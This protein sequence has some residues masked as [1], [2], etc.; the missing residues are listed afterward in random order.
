M[1]HVVIGAGPAGVTACETLRQLD[2]GTRITLVGDE[3]EPPYSRMAIP[4]F[5]TEKIG[6]Q[7]THLKSTADF[8]GRNGINV[9]QVR[10]DRIEP[11]ANRLRMDD[12]STLDY[13][14]LL[15][16]TGSSPILPSVPG[17]E[18]DGV[19]ACW[20]LSD[21]RRIYRRARPG[22]KVVLL[23]AGF[24]GCIVLEA[25]AKRWVDL[26]VVEPMDRMVPRMMSQTA[27]G[28]LKRWCEHKGVKVLTG[29]EAVAVQPRKKVPQTGILGPMGVDLDNGTTL[30]ADL[31]IRATGVRPNV[32]L[33]AGSG[34][35]VDQ[36]ILVNEYL[37]TSNENVFAA[38]DACQGLDTSTGEFRVQAIQPTAVDHGRIAAYNMTSD[39]RISHSG[40]LN[41]NVLDTLGLIS[42]SFGLWQGVDGGESSELLDA[43]RFRYL[44]LQF[45]ED[46]L[47]GATSL[48]LTENVGVIR[49]L[50]E[51]GKGLGAWKDRLLRD[52]TRLMEAYLG[53]VQGYA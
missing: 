33:L 18:S 35:A 39:R 28:L 2:P 4:Y 44:N 26:T 1:H 37:M 22:R 30:K 27:G 25:L 9:L 5:L 41:M 31:I 32:D 29:T 40:S 10:V 43:D 19:L 51:S 12:G 36:G 24:I 48:G 52:P 8:Y 23:G 13:D 16:A 17:I 45:R 20:T 46:H 50:V 6:E 34:I 21:A 47:V 15:I 14:R 42:S 7:G 38:G 3:R 53:S 11:G 49:G